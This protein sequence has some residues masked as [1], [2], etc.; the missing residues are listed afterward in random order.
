MPLPTPGVKSREKARVL[1]KGLTFLEWS[2]ECYCYVVTTQAHIAALF[3]SNLPFTGETE[4]RQLSL[5]QPCNLPLGESLPCFAG[6]LSHLCFLGRPAQRYQNLQARPTKGY[7]WNLIKRPT[8]MGLFTLPLEALTL[9]IFK[10]DQNTNNEGSALHN[11]L[12]RI[13]VSWYTYL[14]LPKKR[15]QAFPWF[16]HV[17]GERGR[18]TARIQPYFFFFL[19]ILLCLAPWHLFSCVRDLEKPFSAVLGGMV[20]MLGIIKLQAPTLQ[21]ALKSGREQFQACKWG[22]TGTQREKNLCH[23]AVISFLYILLPLQPRT[24]TRGGA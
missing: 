21:V 7:V 10:S 9:K 13:Y 8:K 6:L 12:F 15:G 1:S 14:T 23:L 24:R 19:V 20:Q 22:P 3:H 17:S 16:W 11:R 4:A 18:K 2:T 5:A